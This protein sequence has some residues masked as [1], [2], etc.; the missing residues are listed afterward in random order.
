MSSLELPRQPGIR[1]LER[2]QAQVV[3][4]I[5]I[6]PLASMAVYLAEVIA[7]EEGKVGIPLETVNEA[8]EAGGLL[9]V[10]V[11]WFAHAVGTAVPEGVFFDFEILYTVEL[12]ISWWCHPQW[13]RLWAVVLVLSGSDDTDRPAGR[14]RSTSKRVKSRMVGVELCS[15]RYKSRDDGPSRRVIGTWGRSRSP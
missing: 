8:L 11:L 6:T 12:D 7:R 15:R 5:S 13:S 14:A 4:V 10:V 1:R 2:R 9:V 3:I